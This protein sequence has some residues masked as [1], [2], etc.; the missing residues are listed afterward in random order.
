MDTEFEGYTPNNDYD[1]VAFE[2]IRVISSI[3]L[4]AKRDSKLKYAVELAKQ[5]LSELDDAETEHM[6]ELN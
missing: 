6:K 2:L 4:L 1:H 5:A 3:E